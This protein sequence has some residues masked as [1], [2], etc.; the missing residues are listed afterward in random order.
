MCC[1]ELSLSATRLGIDLIESLG[2]H[3]QAID[4]ITFCCSVRSPRAKGHQPYQDRHSYLR[5]YH[6]HMIEDRMEV[7]FYSLAKIEAVIGQRPNID[8]LVALL[9]AVTTD[10]IEMTSSRRI[11]RTPRSLFV[12]SKTISIRSAARAGLFFSLSACSCTSI[13]ARWIWSGSANSPVPLRLLSVAQ[14]VH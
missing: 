2:F 6:Q 1:S 8:F 11:D 5:I 4:V 10:H 9:Q 7:Q 3:D 12:N 14:A 13:R